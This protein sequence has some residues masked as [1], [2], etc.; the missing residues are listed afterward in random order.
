M[1]ER[2]NV[3]DI[4][5]RKRRASTTHAR[6]IDDFLDGQNNQIDTEK[7]QSNIFHRQNTASNHQKTDEKSLKVIS[8]PKGVDINTIETYTYLTE[9]QP[10]RVYVLDSGFDGT[11]PVGAHN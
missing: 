4:A 11:H 2:N 3:K 5:N 6:S 9:D 10:A 1:K 8:Q 7:A